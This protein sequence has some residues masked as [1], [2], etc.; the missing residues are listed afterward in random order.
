MIGPQLS[1]TAFYDCPLLLQEKGNSRKQD[2]ED[3][4]Q[5]QQ[6][7]SEASEAESWLLEKEPIACGTDY[8]KDEDTA[9]VHVV[10]SYIVD[11]LLKS[12]LRIVVLMHFIRT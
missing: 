1:L 10:Q 9:Q 4:V 11:L 6:Y 3:S 2:L 8:G 7:L 12:C 5:T